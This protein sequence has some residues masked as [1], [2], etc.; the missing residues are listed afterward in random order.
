ML[1]TVALSAGLFLLQGEPPAIKAKDAKKYVGK[2]VTMCGMAIKAECSGPAERMVIDLDA[3]LLEDVGVAVTIAPDGRG[4]LASRFED[5]IALRQVCATGV[6]QATG[7]GRFVVA[8]DK[9]DALQIKAQPAK[10]P[11]LL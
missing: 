9:G 2:A 7:K 8:L 4:P 5:S 10:P 11:G 3:I 1:R 6:L